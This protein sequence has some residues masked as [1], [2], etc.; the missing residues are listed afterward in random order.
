VFTYNL[1]D[2]GDFGRFSAVLGAVT[3]RRLTY[4]EVT[5]QD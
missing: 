1:P 2:S 5:G 4:A 3:R